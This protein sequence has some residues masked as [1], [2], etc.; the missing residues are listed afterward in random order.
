MPSTATHH[1]LNLQPEFSQKS[2]QIKNALILK[3]NFN[4]KTEGT[5]SEIS[6]NQRFK[7][8]VLGRKS[9]NHP[10]N[11]YPL[12]TT[13]NTTYSPLIRGIKSSH[14]SGAYMNSYIQH[15][16]FDNNSSLSSFTNSRNLIA[17]IEFKMFKKASEEREQKDTSEKGTIVTLL[18]NTQKQLKCLSYKLSTVISDGNY[19]NL[20]EEGQ[21]TRIEVI[22]ET[23]IYCKVGLKF[24]YSPMIIK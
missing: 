16:D 6:L 2:L 20:L 9:R 7:N 14:E 13:D 1:S 11:P 19:H 12:I 24:K 22:E 4:L 21:L 5:S 3:N 17:S 8:Q 15:R 23:L 10:Y 18:K